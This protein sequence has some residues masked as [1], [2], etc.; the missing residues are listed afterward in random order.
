VNS[1]KKIDCSLIFHGLEHGFFNK[2][3]HENGR[4]MYHTMIK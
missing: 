4:Q 1:E 2:K 3:N